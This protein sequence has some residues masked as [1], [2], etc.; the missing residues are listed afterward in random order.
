V[1]DAGGA[2][3]GGATVRLI[4]PDGTGQS[5]KT[6]TDRTGAFE[7]LDVAPGWYVLSGFAP[8][9]TDAVKLAD[10]EDGST[11]T[12]VLTLPVNRNLGGAIVYPVSKPLPPSPIPVLTVCEAL[13][14]RDA[15]SGQLAVIVGI[16]KSGMDETQRLDCP[17][18]LM[19]GEVGWP[20]SIGLA[21]PALPPDALRNEIEKKR[22]EVLKSGPPGAQ[23]RPERVVGLYGT[24]VAV[25]G[26][27]SAPCCSAAVETTIPPARLFGPSEKDLRV[28]R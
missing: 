17:F 25:D 3:I 26:L 14:K 9:F 12:G 16:F 8:G 15:I 5:I 18:Q 13:E 20:S 2:S 22:A 21:G 7:F 28:I 19:T 24:F 27:I 23:P 6:Q 1:A 11:N 10:I 4:R